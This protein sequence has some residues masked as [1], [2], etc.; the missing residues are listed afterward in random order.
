MLSERLPGLFNLPCSAEVLMDSIPLSVHSLMLLSLCV[1]TVG[2]CGWRAGRGPT[3]CQ[4]V[5]Q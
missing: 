1:S 5:S 3:A 2:D 4:P